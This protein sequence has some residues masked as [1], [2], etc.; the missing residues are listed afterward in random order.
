MFNMPR[1]SHLLDFKHR[2]NVALKL[3]VQQAAWKI[4]D[5]S[6]DT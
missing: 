3:F 5:F 6:E 2:K 1:Q 4:D